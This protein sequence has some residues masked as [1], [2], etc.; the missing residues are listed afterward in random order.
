MAA[1]SF[2]PHGQTQFKNW[3]NNFNSQLPALATKYGLTTAQTD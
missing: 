2:M 3:H 1:Q